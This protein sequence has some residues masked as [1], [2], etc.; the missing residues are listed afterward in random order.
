MTA[1]PPE[2]DFDVLTLLEERYG[3]WTTLIS[4]LYAED[5]HDVDINGKMVT[6]AEVR[7]R[8][9]VLGT[10]T[11]CIARA[12]LAERKERRRFRKTL[13]Q[14]DLPTL[15]DEQREG[16]HQHGTCTD[17]MLELLAQ[18]NGAADPWEEATVRSG[19]AYIQHKLENWTPGR[20]DTAARDAVVRLLLE[21]GM[22]EFVARKEQDS[23]G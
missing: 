21:T 3:D 6:Q 9:R 19:L 5:H 15:T 2:L 7:V 1:T 23:R 13:A 11:D 12:S 18:Q 14:M 8:L 10:V 17:L 16:W 22:T 20:D 4:N